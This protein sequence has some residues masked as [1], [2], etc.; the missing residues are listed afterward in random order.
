MTWAMKLMGAYRCVATGAFSG[1]LAH[2]V[3]STALGIRQPFF[4][5]FGR[6][7]IAQSAS[8]LF[9]VGWRLTEFQSVLRFQYVT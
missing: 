1:L 9:E 7:A 4:V 6:R 2:A 3:V 5:R 8:S